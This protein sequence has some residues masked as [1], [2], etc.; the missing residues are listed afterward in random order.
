MAELFREGL[1]KDLPEVMEI[2]LN[3][4]SSPYK[5]ET[6][7]E[8]FKTMCQKIIVVQEEQEIIGYVF[9]GMA[10]DEAE[11]YRIAIRK[12]KEGHGEGTKLLNWLES[13]L[14][15]KG[16]RTIFLEVRKS[17]LHAQHLYEKNG[18]IYYRTR[19]AYYDNN[20]DA[21]CLKKGI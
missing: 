15:E 9:F 7:Q 4:F 5:K 1:E 13:Y 3:R 11:I 8:A 19:K 12:D 2:D 10:A 14:K 16:I 21:L 18:F 6:F 20:E 17:N